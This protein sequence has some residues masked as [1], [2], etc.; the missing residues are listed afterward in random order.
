MATEYLRLSRRHRSIG[1]ASDE[2]EQ[3]A[4]TRTGRQNGRPRMPSAMVQPADFGKL[5][6][7]TRGHERV[8]PRA[9]RRRE[10]LHDPRALYAMPK[11][12]TVDAVAVVE[13]VGRRGVVREGVDELLCGPGGGGCSVTLKWTTRRRWWAK[14]TR[15]KST[16][17]LTVGTTKKSRDTRSCT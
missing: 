15:T 12:L 3:A 6:D 11:W 14:M 16:L 17:C 8:L 13:E 1:F 5:H 7:L 9:L 10:H 4:K 2:R